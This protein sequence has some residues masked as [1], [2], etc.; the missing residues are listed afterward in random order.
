MFALYQIER[1]GGHVVAQ[2]VETKFVVGT[3]GDVGQI[4]L[5]TFF[6]IGA[7][8]V[9]TIHRQ[10]MEHIQRSHP[11]RVTLRQVIVHG[12]HV[13][14]VPGQGVQEYGQGG[15]Q[16]FTLTGSHFRNLAF[17]QHHAAEELDIVM[18]HVP[19][20]FISSSHPVVGIDGFVSLDADKVVRSCQV[21]VEG[22]GGHLDFRLLDKTAGRLPHNGEYIGQGVVQL[23]FQLI[24]NSLLNLIDFVIPGFPVINVHLFDGNFQFLDALPVTGDTSLYGGTDIR[25]FLSQFVVRKILNTCGGLFDPFHPGGNIFQVSLGLVAK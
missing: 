18:H 13:D 1:A 10:T 3:E 20:D 8:L 16:G 9:D 4:G 14:T 7:V 15:D 22:S 24:E 5:T 11:F 23:R 12:D 21:T 17:V 2:V 6:R 19:D 25:A